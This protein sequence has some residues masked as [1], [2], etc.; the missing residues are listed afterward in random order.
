VAEWASVAARRS[1]T[2]NA[3]G[4]CAQPCFLAWPR[5]KQTRHDRHMHRVPWSI[6]AT[7]ARL[8]PH[9]RRGRRPSACCSPCRPMVP[10]T[11]AGAV[12]AL[13]C[14]RDRR[15]ARGAVSRVAD[16]VRWPVL[17]PTRLPGSRM[18]SPAPGA[19]ARRGRGTPCPAPAHGGVSCPAEGCAAGSGGG[20]RRRRQPC[21]PAVPG[22][23]QGG[24][25]LPGG[26]AGRGGARTLHPCAGC[27]VH[28][29]HP[30]PTGWCGIRRPGWGPRGGRRSVTGK[31][32][33]PR[34]FP[35]TQQGLAGDGE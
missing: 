30:R 2:P 17:A 16:V 7:P 29:H 33:H 3:L 35:A 9:G 10:C 22:M 1:L 6:A 24:I 25:A 32:G 28:C 4:C 5:A 14:V 34:R 23:H 31:S 21:A 12:W 27:S 13:S 11:L 20:G 18:A 15:V 26:R 19:R 8:R